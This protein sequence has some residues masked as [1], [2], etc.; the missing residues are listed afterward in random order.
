MKMKMTEDNIFLLTPFFPELLDM[1]MMTMMMTQ[2]V[3]IGRIC[4]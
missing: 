1:I 2:Q 3:K 4:F